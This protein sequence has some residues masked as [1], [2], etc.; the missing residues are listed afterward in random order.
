[1]YKSQQPFISNSKLT[2]FQQKLEKLE[3]KRSQLM[4][5]GKYLESVR[6]NEEIEQVRKL[7]EKEKQY[8]PKPLKDLVDRDKAKEAVALI[9]ECHLAADFLTA[10]AYALKDWFKVQ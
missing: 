5:S 6:M 9:V 1:M 3:A 7:I 4:R 8:Q 2:R 10:T